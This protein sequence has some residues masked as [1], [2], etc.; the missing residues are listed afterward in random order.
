MRGGAFDAKT[1]VLTSEVRGVILAAGMRV[2]PYTPTTLGPRLRGDDDEEGGGS[3]GHCG[4]A[5]A[6]PWHGSDAI[7]ARTA[8]S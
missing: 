3:R 5:I 4:F 6:M 7:D 8:P 2:I 1:P